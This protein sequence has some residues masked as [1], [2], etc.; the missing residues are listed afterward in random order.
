M[1]LVAHD[2]RTGYENKRD[3]KLKNNQGSLKV[4]FVT[5]ISKAGK[6]SKHLN[7]PHLRYQPSGVYACQDGNHDHNQQRKSDRLQEVAK[8]GYFNG[9]DLSQQPKPEHAETE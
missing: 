4:D 8:R 5:G 7:R 6:I 1:Q 9:N 3:N 2:E